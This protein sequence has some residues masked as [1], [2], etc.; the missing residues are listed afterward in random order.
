MKAR[1]SVVEFGGQHFDYVITVC[2]RAKE[3]CP[4]SQGLRVPST[5]ALTILLQ[6]LNRYAGKYSGGCGMKLPISSAGSSWKT[7][8]LLRLHFDVI[9]VS[10]R[11]LF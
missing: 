11:L 10:H 8:G 5:G 3:A 4:M 7:S 6:H 9:A 2:D 1:I